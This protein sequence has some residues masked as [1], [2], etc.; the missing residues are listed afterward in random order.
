MKKY[1]FLF[2]VLLLIVCTTSCSQATKLEP[3]AKH[4]IM[5]AFDGWGAYSVPKADIPHI[6]A[7]M[8]KG[9]YTLKKRSVLPSAS[10]INW[11]SMFNGAGTEM[12]GYTQWGSRIPEIPSMV[13]NE[14]GIFPTI[15]SLMDEQMPDAE[16]GCLFEWEGIKY[17]VD[18]LSIDYV[19]Q[20]R[21]VEEEPDQLCR[22]TEE[23][24]KREKPTF[25]AVCFDQLDHA[26]H[27]EGHDTPGYY[28]KLEELDVYVGRI[29]QAVKDAGIY[30]DSIIILTAD[31][32]GIDKGHGGITLQEMEIP[33]II[34]GKSVKQGGEFQECMMQFDTAAT[35]A[36]IFALQ[37]P[38][39][40]IGRP[41]KQ[42]FE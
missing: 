36:Y 2:Y 37:Q 15:Y 25:V 10:A 33:F 17:L 11:A 24:I 7:L 20:A 28:R 34:A 39:A 16:T 1:L 29:V 4:V 41:M 13:I 22:I 19:A 3:K 5:I 40:W 21:E 18:T 38:Q 12:H 31:H 8:Q 35:I 26:G 42:V 30:D 6:K 27:S 14:H 9:C 23:Y 32:G